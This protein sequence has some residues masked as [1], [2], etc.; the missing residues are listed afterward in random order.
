[1][2][3]VA[4]CDGR[5]LP[6]ARYGVDLAKVPDTYVEPF[7]A[8]RAWNWTA[9]GVT[10][11][12]GALWT[13]KVAF[14]ATCLHADDLRSM[15]A[16]CS[17]EAS[18]K[19]WQK[20]AHHVPDPSCTC[21]MYA[22]IN[23]QHLI[24]IRYIQRGIHGEVHLWGRLFVGPQPDMRSNRLYARFRELLLKGSSLKPDA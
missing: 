16:A 11:L 19:F 3:R 9:E 17:S 23:M 24:D 10:S 20:Q 15:Q 18:S 14:E 6:H 13:P 4:R 8:Y 12:N 2:P 5:S 7:T 22:G 21:G 1:M